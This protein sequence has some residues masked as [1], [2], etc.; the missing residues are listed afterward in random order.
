MSAALK[1][2]YWKQLKELGIEFELPYRNYTL[3]QLRDSYEALV[4]EGLASP[5]DEDAARASYQAKA[6]SQAPVEPQPQSQPTA[7][8]APTPASAVPVS[9]Q[10]V[11]EHAAERAYSAGYDEEPVRIDP[12]TKFVWFREEV[13]KPAAPRPRARRKLTYVDP[14]TKTMEVSDGR[15]VETVEVSGQQRNTGEVRITMPSYQ[16]G[17]YLDPKFKDEVQIADPSSSG[18]AYVFLATTVQRL[19]EDKGFEFLK[20]LHKNISQ[21]TKSGI[22]PVKA[23]ALG[24]TAVG[25]AFMHDMLTQ[26]LQGAPIGT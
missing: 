26:K 9:S 19:G 17:V 23:T 3:A 18:A 12:V 15:Y 13:R 14:G 1:G 10:S 7:P 6:A 20:S 4:K 16:V 2:F 25:I 8:T 24:E 5:V 21:Y 22:A 11:H